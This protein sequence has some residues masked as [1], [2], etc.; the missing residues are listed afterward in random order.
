MEGQRG[1]WPETGGME[2][3][4]CPGG[5]ERVGVASSRSKQRRSRDRGP[6]NGA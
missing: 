4:E 3:N 1:R 5:E 2:E 6:G